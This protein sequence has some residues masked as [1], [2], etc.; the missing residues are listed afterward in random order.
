MS[1]AQQ[2]APTFPDSSKCGICYINSRCS[3]GVC[4]SCLPAEEGRHLTI[5]SYIRIFHG[6]RQKWNKCEQK[7]CDHFKKRLQER[8]DNLPPVFLTRFIQGKSEIQI[9]IPG[10]TPRDTKMVMTIS[11]VPS[12]GQYRSLT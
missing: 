3:G 7:F 6:Q 12:S 2:Q 1:H 4:T 5:E 8:F 10:S 9:G 11:Y